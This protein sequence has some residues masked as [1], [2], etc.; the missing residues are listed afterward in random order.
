MSNM[1]N[2]TRKQLEAFASYVLQRLDLQGWR[3]EWTSE[4]PS[5]CVRET[6][7]ILIAVANTGFRIYKGYPWQAKEAI[8]HEIAHILTLDMVHGEDFY[9][10]YTRLL[11]DFVCCE[12]QGTGRMIAGKG[13]H[14]EKTEIFRP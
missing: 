6:K 13:T 8:L 9:R 14:I 2:I 1:G 10:G 3:M 7:V 12:F 5:F 11:R 4:N